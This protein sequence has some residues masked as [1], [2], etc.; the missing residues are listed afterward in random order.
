MAL[1]WLDHPVMLHSSRKDTCKLTVAQCKYRSGHWR[2]WYQADHVYGHATIYFMCAII[3]SFMV[4]HYSGR[5]LALLKKDN[6]LRGNNSWQKVVGTVR[7]L[8]NKTFRVQAL[9]WYSSSMG[10]IL[11]GLAG[12]MYFFSLTLGPKP[13][14]WPNTKTLSYGGS[15]PI[16]TRTG[17]MSL[18]LM[19]F[20]MMVSSKTNWITLLTGISHEKLQVFHRWIS[21][22]MFILALIH[23][24][25]FIIVHI[26]KGDMMMQWQM[27]VVYWTGVAALIPQAWLNIMSIGPIR[28]RFYESFKAGHYIAIVLFLFFLFIHCDFRLTSWDYFIATLALYLPTLIYSWARTATHTNPPHRAHLSILP[29]QTLHISIP[30][31]MSWAPGQHVFLRFRG[32]GIHTLAT[33]PFTICSLP[34]SQQMEFF[35]KIRGGITS[36]LAKLAE[37]SASVPVSIDGPYGSAVVAEY[38]NGCEKVLLVAGGSGAGYLLPFVESLLAAGK[39]VQ[40]VLAVRHRESAAWFT[41]VVEKII[42]FEEKTSIGVEIHVTDDIPGRNGKEAA[43]DTS[44]TGTPTLDTCLVAEDIEKVTINSKNK[45]VYQAQSSTITIIEGNGRPQLRKLIEDLTAGGGSVGI[46]ACGPAGMMYDVQNA[47]ADAQAR[48]VK[49]ESEGSVWLHSEAFSW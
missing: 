29:D 2:Y 34:S 7:Y 38:L 28:N 32:V 49:G 33:H 43:H 37:N 46:T 31:P 3:G 45:H 13:Y 35:I 36:R 9:G 18:A 24:F 8:S 39:A 16:A 15:P 12:V 20:L 40:V 30:T 21:W 47:C 41:E 25:P 10:A 6:P 4:A 27:S 26:Q 14:Y 11:L 1:P 19:P 17:W 42:R 5:L 23:T 44:G 48:I 22:T